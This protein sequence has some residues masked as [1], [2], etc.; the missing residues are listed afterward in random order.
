MRSRGPRF[1]RPR[2]TRSGRAPAAAAGR[3]HALDRVRARRKSSMDE[4]TPI[5]YMSLSVGT[6]VL[7]SSGLQFATV[8][9]VLQVPELDI[10]DGIAVKT[11]R[12]C[13]SSTGTR[14]PTSP[15]RWCAAPSPTTRRRPCPPRG[16]RSSCTPTRRTMRDRHSPPG[17]V[18]SSGASTGR[19]WNSPT[20]TAVRPLRGLPPMPALILRRDANQSAGG[21]SFGAGPAT[22][23]ASPSAL[24]RPTRSSRTSSDSSRASMSPAANPTRSVVTPASR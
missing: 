2:T 6:A 14:S 18:A 17:S 24:T 5:S 20:V 16:A 1:D 22:A 3:R 7:S 4:G 23:V 15:P 21:R 11:K 8:A 9:H 10:F 12:G 13:A 19:S